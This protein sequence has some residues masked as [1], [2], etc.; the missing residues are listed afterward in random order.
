MLDLIDIVSI[1]CE[2]TVLVT[3][4]IPLQRKKQMDHQAYSIIAIVILLI[5]NAFFVAAEFALV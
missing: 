2:Y 4:T 5:I 1:H 3:L